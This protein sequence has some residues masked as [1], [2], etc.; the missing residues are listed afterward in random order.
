MRP[1]IRIFPQLKLISLMTDQSNPG[2]WLA[3]A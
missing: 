2:P 3:A 1:S